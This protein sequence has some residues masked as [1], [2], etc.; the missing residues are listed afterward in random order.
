MGMTAQRLNLRCFIDGIE[1]PVIGCRCTFQ[2]GAAA[3]AEIQL[4]PTDEVYDIE[5]RAFV[6][7][8]YYET[9]DYDRV[10]TGDLRLQRLGPKDLRRWKLLFAGEFITI[11]FQ[12]QASGR[13]VSLICVDH[14][15]Y[16]DFIKQYYINFQNAG[17]ELYENAFLGVKLDRIKNYDVV[18][19]DMSSNLFVWLTRSKGPGGKPNLYLGMQRTLREMWFA[20]NDFYARAFNRLRVGDMIVGLPDDQT[21]AKLFQLEFFEKFIKEQIGGGG[22]EVTVR[23]MIDNLLGT[24]MHT[25]VTVP[26]PMFDRKGVCRGFSPSSTSTQDRLL[27]SENISREL[28]WPEAALNYT[29]IKPDTWFTAP[30]SCNII[31]PHQYSAMSF[32]RNY[33]QEPTRLFLRTQPLFSGGQDKWITERFY[34]PD[35]EE[36][37]KLM[38]KEGGHLERM[39]ETVL[40]HEEFVGLNPAMAWQPDM[41]AYAQTG[42]RREYFAKL[43]DYLYWKMRFGGRGVDVSGPFNPNVV[44]GYSGLVIGNVSRPGQVVR[45][46]L[47][48]VQSVTHMIN[49]NGGTTSISMI[50]A[51]VHDETADFD[52]KGRSLEEVTNRGVDGFV[53]DRYDSSKIG[54]EVYPRLFGCNSIV[55]IYGS[56]VSS[57]AE[58]P[59]N[60]RLEALKGAGYGQI[61]LSVEAVHGLY[62]NAV[63]EK[64]DINAF[65][66]SL[67]WRPKANMLEMLG[68]DIVERANESELA[69]DRVAL[70]KSDSELVTNEG[71]FVTCVDP[72][73]ETTI[74]A[75]FTAISTRTI[76]V[77][78]VTQIPEVSV[79]VGNQSS[80]LILKAATT[81]VS[82]TFKEVVKNTKGNYELDKHLNARR[83]KVQAYADSLR[84]RGLRG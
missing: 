4:I 56:A 74:R 21:A 40:K 65:S 51:H 52:G 42:P 34:A 36:L 82:T 71:F 67:S 62:Q 7:L 20:A 6:T 54:T 53:D 59:L 29:I 77:A 84:L 15:N 24:V 9:Y 60:Q 58:D 79:P 27:L 25:Y 8:F 17:I 38:Y 68:T 39:A 55:E 47:G 76:P 80:R 31:F 72:E 5:P 28:S 33:L 11:A 16:W 66:Q 10:P 64:A 69:F 61:A 75:E 49:Q 70:R 46:Y 83:V 12:K 48:H 41:C 1:V 13:S 3:T 63:Q 19:K 30:P 78:T 45:H 35:F 23:Q 14:T 43:A 44:P 73:A 26:C 50:G 2:E 37:N 57:D 22:Q 81:N 32:Q 18:G